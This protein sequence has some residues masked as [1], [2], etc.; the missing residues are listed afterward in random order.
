MGQNQLKGVARWAAI[1]PQAGRE[2]TY[3]WKILHDSVAE[4]RSQLRH[5][6][7]IHRKR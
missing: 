5:K 4:Q 1:Y 6:Q 2:M 7:G 3:D